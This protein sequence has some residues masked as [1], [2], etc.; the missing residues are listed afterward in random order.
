[1]VKLEVMSCKLLSPKGISC[2]AWNRDRSQVAICPNSNVI[3]IYEVSSWKLL[4]SLKEHDLL[5]SGI[6]WDGVNNRIVSCSHDRNAFVWTYQP[7]SNGEPSVW[8]PALVILRL[9]R[10]A[11]DVK[12]DLQGTRFAVGSCSK[13]IPVCT[14]DA[15][16]DWWVS[17]HIKK[18][19][20][21]TVTCVAFHPKNSQVLAAGSSDFKCRV[22]STYSADVDGSEVTDVKSAP[23]N[24]P[25]EFGD[26]YC[27]FSA[28]GWVNAIAWSP[29]GDILSFTSHDS[30]IHFINVASESHAVPQ[31]IKFPDLPLQCLLF[32]SE[33]VLLGGGHDFNLTVYESHGSTWSFKQK[34]DQKKETADTVV[35]AGGST[36]GIG[37]ARALFQSKTK[38][39]QDSKAEGDT[40]WTKHENAITGMSL[41]EE[42]VLTSSLDGKIVIWSTDAL[43]G[44]AS[45]MKL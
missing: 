21:S 14:Y 26:M 7:S 31:T 43:R 30:T 5:V 35:S 20:K 38:T 3:E 41:G 12:W 19:I 32:T 42:S 17:R 37:A 18:K 28:L 22:F 23:F 10:A 1:M 2:H 25:V 6:D 36:G 11:M 34:L 29:S 9:D 24:S 39:G 44:A 16:N 40:L 45:C 33:S 13:V 27:E 4:F 15:E 8:K